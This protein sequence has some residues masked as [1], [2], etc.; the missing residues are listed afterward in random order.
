MSL[1]LL[2]TS[3]WIE[4]F[5]PRPKITQQSLTQLRQSILE[6]EIVM[7]EPIRA[8]LLSGQVRFSKHSELERLLSALT[9]IDLNWNARKTWDSLVKLAS[10]AISNRIPVP[11]L[12][13]RMIL[14]A[15]RESSVAICSLDQSLLKLARCLK[16]DIFPV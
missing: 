6:D 14:L 3:V 11:G 12:I 4:Y 2:D 15:A 10:L 8:E 16:I 13:D 7:I 9:L 1:L 5:S